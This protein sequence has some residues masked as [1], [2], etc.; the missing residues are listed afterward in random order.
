MK[1]Q[2]LWDVTLNLPINTKASEQHI[3]SIFRVKQS[4]DSGIFV[5]FF[6]KHGGKILL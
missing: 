2:V 3:A 6:P 4:K 1:I 5:L